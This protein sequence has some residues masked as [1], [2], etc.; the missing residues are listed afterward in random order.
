MVKLFVL[1]RKFCYIIDLKQTR[2][3][4]NDYWNHHIKKINNNNKK[5]K[6]KNPWPVEIKDYLLQ[7]FTIKFFSYQM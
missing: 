2:H 3:P 7:V 4:L 5:T 6:T 1:D